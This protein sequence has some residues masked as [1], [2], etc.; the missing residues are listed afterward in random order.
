MSYTM[1][2]TVT[3][4]VVMMMISSWQYRRTESRSRLRV[5]PLCALSGDFL[6]VTWKDCERRK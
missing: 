1:L 5:A 4:V 2:L 6:E 3:V